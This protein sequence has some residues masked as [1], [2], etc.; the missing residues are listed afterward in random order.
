MCI[1]VLLWVW[2][3]SIYRAL[4]TRKL[5][6]TYCVDLISRGQNF[7]NW[8]Y[9]PS[10]RG[11]NFANDQTRHM[12]LHWIKLV[13]HCFI[14]LLKRQSFI[15]VQKILIPRFLKAKEE[16]WLLPK[17]KAL[18]IY[19]IFAAHRTVNFKTILHEYNII[20]IFVLASCTSDLQPLD[21]CTPVEKCSLREY[22]KGKYVS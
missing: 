4:R 12:G 13:A 22:E 6:R 2:I 1:Y 9:L 14:G 18:L 20:A 8:G 21:I 15:Y 19:D 16:L 3:W 7:A 10:S 11:L 17:Q 5:L